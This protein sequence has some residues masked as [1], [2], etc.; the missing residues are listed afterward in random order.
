MTNYQLVDVFGSEPCSG[1]PL[2]VIAGAEHLPTDEMQRITRWF[3]YSETAF[4]MPPTDPDADYCVRIFTL[5]RE[6]PFAGHPTL[7]SCHV[8]LAGGG[9][10]R[11]ARRIIQQCGAGL[12]ELRQTEML[13]FAAPPLIRS[14]DVDEADLAMIAD[15]LRLCHQLIERLCCE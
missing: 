5:D 12:V 15:F 2:P 11:E 13:A 3:G 9:M 10:P 8:W 1:N 4:L 14:G 6:L 7:G